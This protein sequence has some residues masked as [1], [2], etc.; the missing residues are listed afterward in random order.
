LFDILHELFVDFSG[1]N[2]L[3][4]FHGFFVGDAQ[5]VYKHGF[6]A[7]FLQGFCDKGAAAVYDNNPYAD[8]LQE[9]EVFHDVFHERLVHHGVSAVFDDDGFA[10]KALY[11]GYG[12]DQHF[13][14]AVAVQM[15]FVCHDASLGAVVAVDFYIVV[16][17][18][19]AVGF[20]L[21]VSVC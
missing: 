6:F 10:G 17:E 9:Y 8:Q 13:G 20:C 15:Q 3:D 1:Q 5:A 14:S 21:C 16:G 18:V 19:A 12:L 4:N 11:I 2:H 7:H